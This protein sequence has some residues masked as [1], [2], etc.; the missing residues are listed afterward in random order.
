MY[1]LSGKRI[2]VTGHKGMVG[3]AIVRQLMHRSDVTLCLASRSELDLT[4]QED[5]NYWMHETRPHVVIHAAGLVGGIWANMTYP[6]NFLYENAIM[7]FNLIHSSHLINLEKF[8]FLGSS[9]IYPKLAPQPISENALLTGPLEP[10]NEAYAIAK[11][12]GV[13]LCQAYRSQ[14]NNDFNSVMPTNL[15][16]PSDNF[17]LDSSHVIPALMRKAHEAKLS[18]AESMTIWGSGRPAREFMHVDDCANGCIFILENMSRDAPIN[19]GSGQEVKIEELA[20]LIMKIV[21]FKGELIKDLSKPD[22][23]PRKLM[24]SKTLLSAGWSP[25]IALEEGLSMTYQKKFCN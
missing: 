9:C 20:R 24:D 21:G 10:T 16:G 5:V 18:G 19:L 7:A 22:G 25:S 14:F 3:E 17:D 12:A 15:Y 4:R 1:N 13:K 2:F 11:I 6:A 8:L 23:T